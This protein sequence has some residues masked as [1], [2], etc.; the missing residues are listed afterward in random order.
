MSSRLFS[1]CPCF[2]HLRGGDT[3]R[4]LYVNNF[5]TYFSPSQRSLNNDTL[6]GKRTSKM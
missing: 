2:Y 4:E 1:T 5:F 3:A 6:Y